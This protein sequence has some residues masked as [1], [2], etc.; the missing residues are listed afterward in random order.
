MDLLKEEKI[1]VFKEVLVEL[2][3]E[4]DDETVQSIVSNYDPDRH[5]TNLY[6]RHFSVIN[7]NSMIMNTLYNYTMNPEKLAEA[8][9]LLTLPYFQLHYY[10]YPVPDHF[11]QYTAANAATETYKQLKD[12]SHVMFVTHNQF[13]Q[14]ENNEKI[15]ALGYVSVSISEV[16][17]KRGDIH[18]LSDKVFPGVLILLSTGGKAPQLHIYPRIFRQ[19]CAN[20]AVMLCHTNQTHEIPLDREDLSETISHTIKDCIMNRETY[21]QAVN[22]MRSAAATP[23]KNPLSLLNRYLGHM[24]KQARE[25]ISQLRSIIG[26]FASKRMYSVWGLANAVT[27]LARDTRDIREALEL[28]KIGGLIIA[29][30]SQLERD[31]DSVSGRPGVKEVMMER[32]Y[33]N[34]VKNRKWHVSV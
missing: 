1:K 25:R 16:V 23:V 22:R 4:L 32:I 9:F 6:W 26:R 28:E 8:Q 30:A 20:G 15:L 12:H 3:P 29:N 5:N 7:R 18:N 27:E 34:Y 24:K 31:D 14:M 33:A 21:L 19:V 17:A 13:L 10:S 2:N 11:Y